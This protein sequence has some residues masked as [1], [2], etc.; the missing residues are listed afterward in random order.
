MASRHLSRISV[1]QALFTSDMHGDLSL[2]RVL[3]DLQANTASVPQ[4]DEDQPFSEKLLRGIVAKRA[5]IDAVIEKAAPQWPLAKIA[6]VDRNV[7]R[8]GLYELLYGDT[9]SVPPKVA[10]NEAIELAKTFGGDSSSRF[11]NGVLGAV[12]RSIGSPRRDEAPKEKPDGRVKEYR[13]GVFVALVRNGTVSLALV[14]DRFDQWTLPKVRAE[15][16]E[17]S[18]TA[19][20]RAIEEM[21]GIVLSVPFSPLGEHEHEA[22]EPGTGTFVRHIAYFLACAEK[23][24]TLHVPDGASI[25]EARWVS[26]HELAELPLYDDLRAIIDSGVALAR[27][28]CTQVL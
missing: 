22:H 12:Y 28:K 10:L 27:K 13:A 23:K 25:T 14:R 18:E 9:A 3:K 6:A 4:G 8:L 21:L 17:L 20:R 2:L 11:V 5:E 1:L 15:E 24:Y 16:E 26:E 19:A 7:L